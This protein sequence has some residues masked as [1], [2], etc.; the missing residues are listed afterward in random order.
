MPR[1]SKSRFMAGLQCYKRLY[2]ELFQSELADPI[3]EAQQAIFDSGTEVGALAR[4][5]CPGGVLI[6]QDHMHHKEAIAYT[7]ELLADRSVSSL[8]EAA[9]L[10]DDVRVRADI[11]VRVDNG[12][13]DLIEVKSG[14]SLKSEHIPDVTIQVY[15]LEGCGLRMGR[16][17]LAHLNKEYVYPGGEYDIGQLF[18]TEDVTEK[19]KQL[20][21]DVPSMLA[22][23]RAPLVGPEPPPVETGRHCSNPYTCEFY[24][25]CHADEPKHH[26]RQLPNARQLAHMVLWLIHMTMAIELTG[27]GI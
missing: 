8:Y 24:S 6:A 26:V 22:G 7:A 21:P 14:N 4:Q 5:I 25:H 11:L 27:I 17:C 23:M 12:M 16:A 19:V 10:Y 13:F 3:G 2:L 18:V 9:F 15:V 1:L 20:L